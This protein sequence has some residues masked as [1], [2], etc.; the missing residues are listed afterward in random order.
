MPPETHK[1]DGSAA[2]N[3]FDTAANYDSV[4]VPASTDTVIFPALAAA[5]GINVD[6]SDQSALLLAAF[7][8]EPGCYVEFGSRIAYLQL[9]TDLL[10]FAGSGQAFL[11]VDNCAEIRVTDA[12]YSTSAT[13]YGL[14][15]VGEG[16][17][18][19]TLDPGSNRGV[20]LAALGDEAFACTTI[21]ADSGRISLGSG[22]TNTTLS[23]SGAD[24]ETRSDHTTTNVYGGV[25]R[26]SDNK[27]TTLNLR[28]GT[29][30]YNRPT[31]DAPTT[32]SMYANAILDL[33]E[34]TAA[35]AIA[36]I[37]IYG[38]CLIRGDRG[39]L[40]WTTM[41]RYNNGDIRFL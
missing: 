39:L 11:D 4:D 32:L 36:T 2:D 30:Y 41:N 34:L 13:D 12:A 8:N 18:L 21:Q 23:V 1:W 24:L 35:L 20:S 9:D 27:S 14:C 6:G 16:N 25:F 38:K 7:W 31:S 29:T 5:S 17:T 26:Q 3:A 33:T 28:G 19:L 40:S 15:L 10:V 22:V 37:N